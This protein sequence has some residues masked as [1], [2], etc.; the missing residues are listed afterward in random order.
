[1]ALFFATFSR[2][3]SDS[4]RPSDDDPRHSSTLP[5][6]E[7]VDLTAIRPARE[8]LNLILESSSVEKLGEITYESVRR[9]LHEFEGLKELNPTLASRN[10]W[11][12]KLRTQSKI[13]VLISKVRHRS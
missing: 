4:E 10:T 6:G 12:W 2:E 9:F 1:M 3:G 11:F 8:A 5:Q 13:D 7:T